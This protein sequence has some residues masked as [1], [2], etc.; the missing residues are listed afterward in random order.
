MNKESRLHTIAKIFQRVLPKHMEPVVLMRVVYCD[1][2]SNEDRGSK[3]E[4]IRRGW[5]FGKGQTFC[6]RHD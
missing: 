3:D 4:L 5:S 2:C 1:I 6:P